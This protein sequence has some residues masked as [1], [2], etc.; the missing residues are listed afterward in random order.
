MQNPAPG[1]AARTAQV[2]DLPRRP[3]H[4][5]LPPHVGVAAGGVVLGVPHGSEDQMGPGVVGWLLPGGM[6][7]GTAWMDDSW[8]I[9]L[10]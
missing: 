6:G 10:T 2:D 1:E 7:Q 4:G 8:T 5:A 3:V 9:G